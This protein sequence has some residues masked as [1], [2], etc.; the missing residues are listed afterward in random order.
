MK[1]YHDFKN[2]LRS[3]NINVL[4]YLLLVDCLFGIVIKAGYER[5]SMALM[6]HFELSVAVVMRPWLLLQNNF[7]IGCLFYSLFLIF[8]SLIA[9]QLAL[10]LFGITH[11]SDQIRISDFWMTTWRRFK[12]YFSW[13]NVWRIGGLAMVSWPFASAIFMQDYWTAFRLNE[14]IWYPITAPSLALRWLSIFLMLSY[15]GVCFWTIDQFKRTLKF[16]LFLSKLVKL[17]FFELGLY[18]IIGLIVTILTMGLNNTALQIAAMVMKALRFL[19]G[20]LWL[21]IWCDVPER[22]AG[23]K[24]G[25]VKKWQFVFGFIL[26]G[27]LA[28]TPAPMTTTVAPQWIAH[29]GLNHKNG[30]E[31]SLPALQQ[32][33]MRRPNYV[34]MDVRETADQDFVVIH[35]QKL[36]RLTGHSGD[37]AHKKL[38]SLENYSVTQVGHSAKLVSFSQYLAV[39]QRSRQRLLVELK[40]TPG[41]DVTAMGRRFMSHYGRSLKKQGALIHTTDAKLVATIKKVEPNQKVGYILPVSFWGVPDTKA[42]FFS[43]EGSAY[44]LRHAIKI[45]NRH[46]K[47]Y[48][49]TINDPL[50]LSQSILK[51]P[52]G[53]ISD[54]FFDLKKVM[55]S[56]NDRWLF[57]GAKWAYVNAVN[58]YVPTL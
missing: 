43:I 35:D 4:C 57:L 31:N 39:A 40:P 54:N 5:L 25:Q 53:V 30:V 17:T 23:S 21:R 24:S 14:A 49:W 13:R 50:Q 2:G 1:A 44:D 42:D 15:V 52:H 34:E 18:L 20:I 38:K 37:V 9:F 12:T 48:I 29:K 36:E 16:R 32:T 7:L 8:L 27:S 28:W 10:L 3:L 55:K 45:K 41:N 46:K 22:S 58:L 19:L 56:P 26:L 51:H 33:A 47:V 6:D 11:F